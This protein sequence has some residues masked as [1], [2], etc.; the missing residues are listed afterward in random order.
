MIGIDLGGTKIEGIVLDGETVLVRRRIPTEAE[1]GYEHVV[2]RIAALVG[3]LRREVPAAQGV[4]IG[5]PGSLSA[6]TG[7]LKNSNTQ[8]LNGRPLLLDLERRI[9]Q[10]LRME[11][12]ANCFALAEALAGAGRGHRLVFGV[13]LGTGV[14]GGIVFDGRC[15][16]GP[17]HIAGE[18]GHHS[19][20]P[21]GPPCY[22]GQRGC[23]ESLLAGPALESA[24]QNAG[25]M[26]ASVAQIATRALA[27][28]GVALSVIDRYL[29]L[30]GR[31][32]AN[33]IAILDPS[34]VVLGGGLSNLEALYERG[35]EEVARQ[36]FNDE[37]Q[38][39]IVRNQLGDSAGVI[40]AALLARE[41]S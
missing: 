20:D 21:A 18:W 11:N 6:R 36:V 17:Q 5:T 3:D 15:W 10:P 41:A 37:L 27:G 39:P 25:G 30:F 40:G 26:P 9:A 13:I 2:E 14:G 1:R 38:T 24:Y 16:T 7:L 32:L 34:V 4:G 35:R 12:D 23:V 29:S 31:A 19:I 33:L 22:C 28:E 8:C